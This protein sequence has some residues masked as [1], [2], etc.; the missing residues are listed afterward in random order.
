MFGRRS[1]L[2]FDACSVGLL[3]VV[4][5]Q[6]VW[7]KWLGRCDTLRLYE[8]E[9]W[10]GKRAAAFMLQLHGTET[11]LNAQWRLGEHALQYETSTPKL[12]PNVRTWQINDKWRL[13]F[14][15]L[16]D[17]NSWLFHIPVYIKKGLFKQIMVPLISFNLHFPLIFS[18]GRKRVI[19]KI[20]KELSALNMCKDLEAFGKTMYGILELFWQS[21]FLSLLSQ[22]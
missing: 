6:T 12:I 2:S 7:V 19:T 22:L 1:C 20:V 11:G 15:P 14:C 9:E 10:R 17:S 3:C 13:S 8:C 4:T 16:M 18:V 5:V 21:V